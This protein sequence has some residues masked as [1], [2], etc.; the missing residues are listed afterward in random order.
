MHRSS[1]PSTPNRSQKTVN[2]PNTPPKPPAPEQ[3]SPEELDETPCS[4]VVTV[5]FVCDECGEYEVIK[6]KG[7][8]IQ[9]CLSCGRVSK[10]SKIVSVGIKIDGVWKIKFLP[11]K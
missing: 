11:N 8:M 9:Y 2:N 4:A 1:S 10:T 5:E 3:P 7:T 6:S